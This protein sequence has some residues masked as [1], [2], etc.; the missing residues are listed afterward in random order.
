MSSNDVVGLQRA[1]VE[2][3]TDDEARVLLGSGPP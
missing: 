1:I 2:L 3:V